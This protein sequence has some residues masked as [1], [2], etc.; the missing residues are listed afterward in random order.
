[1]RRI[2]ITIKDG[3]LRVQRDYAKHT[4]IQMEKIDQKP[5]KRRK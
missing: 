1:M 4:E 5:L 2:K 3:W